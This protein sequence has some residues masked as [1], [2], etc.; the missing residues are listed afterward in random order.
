MENLPKWTTSDGGKFQFAEL[1]WMS[2]ET[3]LAVTV[4]LKNGQKSLPFIFH[5][6]F[7]PRNSCFYSDL[8]L[9]KKL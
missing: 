3:S 6:F 4:T 7:I 1:G 8:I 2:L 5:P 9:M